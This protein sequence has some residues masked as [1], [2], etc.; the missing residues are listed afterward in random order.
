MEKCHR[1]VLWGGVVEKFCGE[2][3]AKGCREVWLR[4]VV[5][6]RCGEVL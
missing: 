6:K 1:E 4:S 2:L 5:E 3:V